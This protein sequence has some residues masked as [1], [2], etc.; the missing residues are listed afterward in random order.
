MT[1]S[2]GR[3]EPR[4]RQ[5]RHASGALSVAIFAGD[6]LGFPVKNESFDC[7]IVDSSCRNTADPQRHFDFYEVIYGDLPLSLIKLGVTA[8]LD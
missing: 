5:H 8:K 6:A 1:I 2:L 3:S 4:K 7:A